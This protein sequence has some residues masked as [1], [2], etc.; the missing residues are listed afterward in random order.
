[1]KASIIILI[2]FKG[3][4]SLPAQNF[5][6][7]PSRSSV[8]VE[9][10]LYGRRSILGYMNGVNIGLDIN[11]RWNFSFIHIASMVQSESKL[12]ENHYQGLEASYVIN[13]KHHLK[14]GLSAQAGFYN[15]NYLALHPSIQ[16]KY[17]HES[18]YF[19]ALGVGKS[20]G[21]PLFNLKL[22]AVIFKR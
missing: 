13:P 14:V 6:V 21:F 10:A 16:F 11:S 7:L 8:Q 22:G 2:M 19:V 12:S 15:E 9:V 18:N 17:A 5:Y 20:D 3:I 1:M 4:L